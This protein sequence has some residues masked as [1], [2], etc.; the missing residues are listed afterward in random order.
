MKAVFRRRESLTDAREGRQPYQ[1]RTQSANAETNL[2]MMIF[3]NYCKLFVIAVVLI[4]TRIWEMPYI[5]TN[6]RGVL[7]IIF[8]PYVV[9]FMYVAALVLTLLWR[10]S[11]IAVIVHLA[12]CILFGLLF[13][14]ACFAA[15][16]KLLFFVIIP[17]IF[18]LW[19]MTLCTIAKVWNHDWRKKKPA[20]N[21]SV[22]DE[23]DMHE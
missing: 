15:L 3:F 11:R 13:Y 18:L 6:G 1:R 19:C 12:T 10:R 7:G 5:F 2:R 9:I 22:T 8:R 20:A 4:Q 21:V 14:A 16:V 23:R 17:G